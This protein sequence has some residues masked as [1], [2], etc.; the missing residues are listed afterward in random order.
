MAQARW[1]AARARH[2]RTARRRGGGVHTA[3]HRPR[4]LPPVPVQRRESRD[5]HGEAEAH[6]GPME[7]RRAASWAGLG[8]ARARGGHGARRPFL[9]PPPS[10]SL[11]P[12]LADG[13]CDGARVAGPVPRRC[14]QFF[15]QARSIWRVEL[16]TVLYQ[17]NIVRSIKKNMKMPHTR[18]II[19]ESQFC[20]LLQKM[21]N[22]DQNT[23]A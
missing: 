20:R 15:L 13:G 14:F 18:T 11:S 19:K 17:W 2:G 9:F 10:L 5:G 23:D 1:A 16:D 6:G 8:G 12:L 21:G 22:R 3:R 4:P 7:P